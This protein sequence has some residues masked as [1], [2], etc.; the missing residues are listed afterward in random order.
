[1]ENFNLGDTVNIIGKKEPLLLTAWSSTG[2]A[3]CLWHTKECGYQSIEVDTT[4]L[5][6]IQL[7][8]EQSPDLLFL[9]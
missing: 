7:E 1:M 4:L 8:A 9:G 6:K 3:I 5:E 2:N